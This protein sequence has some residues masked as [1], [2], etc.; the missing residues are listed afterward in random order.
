MPYVQP[1]VTPQGRHGV[2]YN[3]EQSVGIGA[4]N[5][6]EDVRLAQELLR[7]CYGKRAEGLAAD[8][9]IG[10]TTTA[11]IKRFQEDCATAGNRMLVD[12]RVDRALGTVSSVSKTVYAI[13]LLN[14]A[15]YRASPAKFN[16]VPQVVKLNPTP[17]TNPYNA[18]GLAPTGWR[19]MRVTDTHVTIQFEDGREETYRLEGGK[20]QTSQGPQGV[21]GEG[22]WEPGP[23]GQPRRK[24]IIPESGGA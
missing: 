6:R 2:L 18:K 16:A 17:R 14:L 4:T 21:P 15:A 22:D 9:W 24:M 19:W 13:I 5:A 12:G 11:W 23:D 10:P 7:I 1:V 3:V 8:G 20:A